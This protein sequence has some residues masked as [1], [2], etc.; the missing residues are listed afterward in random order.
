MQRFFQLYIISTYIAT[1]CTAMLFH[2]VD[3]LSKHT[4]FQNVCI[5]H[6]IIGVIELRIKN[7][8][9]AFCIDREIS[10]FF[11]SSSSSYNKNGHFLCYEWIL[12]LVKMLFRSPYILCTGSR[13]QLG[14]TTWGDF[15]II[16][17]AAFW[18]HEIWIWLHFFVLFV[19]LMWRTDVP[20]I[21]LKCKRILEVKPSQ[22]LKLWCLL[23]IRKMNK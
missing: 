9:L 23:F 1:V 11:R 8:Y 5:H 18:K 3:T 21:W 22:I 15:D 12:L 14:I 6:N 20:S 13:S 19:W 10:F 7:F 2:S 16:F 4:Y 17:F